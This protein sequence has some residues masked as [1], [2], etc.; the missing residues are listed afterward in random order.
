MLELRVKEQLDLEENIIVITEDKNMDYD[1]FSKLNMFLAKC[2]RNV[3]G[4]IRSNIYSHIGNDQAFKENISKLIK[5]YFHARLGYDSIASYNGYIDACVLIFDLDIFSDLHNAKKNINTLIDKI[6]F[7]K[8]K[9]IKIN[10]E[11]IKIDYIV[12]P[13]YPDISSFVLPYA[14]IDFEYLNTLK[15]DSL[16]SFCREEC[17]INKQKDFLKRGEC[18]CCKIGSDGFPVSK[19]SSKQVLQRF[20]D[21]IF[22]E[23]SIPCL[24]KHYERIQEI[25]GKDKLFDFCIDYFNVQEINIFQVHSCI[26]LLFKLD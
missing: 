18:I 15:V 6:N 22:S 21:A 14:Q 13:S 8:H 2:N 3:K 25:Y 5:E 1:F 9:T 11:V 10:E 7:L 26:S 17:K 23:E 12:L 4:N 19:T 20:Q 16:P 24:E